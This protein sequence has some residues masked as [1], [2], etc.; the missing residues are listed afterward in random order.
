M[1]RTVRLHALTAFYVELKI[2]QQQIQKQNKNIYNNKIM[3]V[4]YAKCYSIK[5][6]VNKQ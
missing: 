6:E 1:F 4:K 2:L 3:D 5:K